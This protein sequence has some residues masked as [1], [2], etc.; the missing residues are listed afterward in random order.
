MGE[1]E[2]G[3]KVNECESDENGRNKFEVGCMEMLV[4]CS[5]CN[6]WEI[7]KMLIFLMN[8]PCQK[9]YHMHYH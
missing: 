1:E 4:D 7:L 5:L 2:V 8:I 9:A 3:I 6:C